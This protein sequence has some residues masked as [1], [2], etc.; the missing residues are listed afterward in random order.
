MELFNKFWIHPEDGLGFELRSLTARF[1]KCLPRNLFLGSA[2]LRT[3]GKVSLSARLVE[4]RLSFR[5]ST[6][7]LIKI[8]PATTCVANCPRTSSSKKF[9]LS[10]TLTFITANGFCCVMARF[11][12]VQVAFFD[13]VFSL[14]FVLFA[15]IVELGLNGSRSVKLWIVL[16]ITDFPVNAEK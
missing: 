14:D 1:C 10:M 12:V 7:R 4:H 15:G 16:A 5:R 13:F 8:F 11:G 6:L 2:L 3:A 9:S